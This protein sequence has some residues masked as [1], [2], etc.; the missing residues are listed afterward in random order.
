MAI[1]RPTKTLK[2]TA[3]EK[4]KLTMLTAARRP[5]KLSRCAP[6]LCSA[7]VMD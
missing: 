5:G 1:G 2:V 4:E 6:A 7:A 3:E